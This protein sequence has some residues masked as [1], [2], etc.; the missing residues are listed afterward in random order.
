MAMKKSTMLL[1]V[2]TMVFISLISTSFA[3]TDTSL[4]FNK[5]GT[6]SEYYNFASNCHHATNCSTKVYSDKYLTEP[7]ATIP[8][9]TYVHTE[10]EFWPLYKDETGYNRWGGSLCTYMLTNGTKGKG[11]IDSRHISS[12]YIQKPD[13][14]GVSLLRIQTGESSDDV[15]G[16]DPVW[17]DISIDSSSENK[18]GKKETI[19]SSTE[20]KT[21]TSKESSSSSKST[22]DVSKDPT[23]WYVTMNAEQRTENV[24]LITLGV[25]NSVIRVGNENKTVP[26][27]QLQFGAA[28]L[29]HTQLIASVLTKKTG[30]V[31]IRSEASENAP[32]IGRIPDGKIVGIV[33]PGETFTKVSYNGIVGYVV[34]R[35]LEFHD[36]NQESIGVGT[37]YQ[38]EKKNI[39]I[40]LEPK[41]DAKWLIKW[42]HGELVTVLAENGQYYAIE[43]DGIHGWVK[44]KYVKLN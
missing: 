33:N 41:N 4:Y 2:C 19:N 38:K 29:D 11:W 6:P 26:T 24:T 27:K 23:I 15:L 44:K 25:T 17:G 39:S 8:K 9:G 18:S 21:S 35:G 1:L 32:S 5:D 3:Y 28:Q 13:G 43:K 30:F 22:K 42:P 40:W 20:E 31:T 10:S 34:T 14:E 7:I 16:A 36:V 12:A 37:L